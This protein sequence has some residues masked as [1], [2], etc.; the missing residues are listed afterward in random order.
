M[1]ETKA[2]QEAGARVAAAVEE[3]ILKMHGNASMRRDRPYDGQPWTDEGE[4]GRTEVRGIT[5]R[6]LRDCFIRAVLLSASDVV[7]K[8]Y[9]EAQL[10]ERAILSGNDLFGF[11]LDKLD[12]LAIGQNLCCE[13]ERIMGIF[14]NVPTLSYEETMEHVPMIDLSPLAPPTPRSDK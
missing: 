4:R 14:P 3:Q 7:P 8:R 6:D 5:F 13:V 9:E 1:D 11:D 10:G 12:P 2:G